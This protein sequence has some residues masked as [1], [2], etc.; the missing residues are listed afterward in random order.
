MSCDLQSYWEGF[1]VSR[2]ASPV[3]VAT[4]GEYRVKRDDTRPLYRFTGR[5][6]A[7]GSTGFAAEPGRYHI[8]AGWFCPWTQRTTIERALHGLQDVVGVS[9][10]D[11]DR[12]SR[13]WAFREKYG[14]DPV[15]G[16]GLLRAAYE[17]AEPGFELYQL[18]AFQEATKFSSFTHPGA[19]VP[20]WDLV[21]ERKR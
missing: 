11:D 7:D 6:T 9:Y 3:D 13:G 16:F 17:A 14:P 10:V 21:V 1:G 19:T 4:Y 20:D 15:N 5:I 18:P 12:D 2:F 8:Y